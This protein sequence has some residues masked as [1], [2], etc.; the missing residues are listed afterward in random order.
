MATIRILGLDPGLSRMGW[1]V[2]DMA[3]T[4]LAHVAHGVVE[5]P[6]MSRFEL[7]ARLLVLHRGARPR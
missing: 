7:A 6:A 2:I 1:G 5:R 3:G 4:R